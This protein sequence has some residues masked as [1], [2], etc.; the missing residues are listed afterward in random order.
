REV[1]QEKELA[2]SVALLDEFPVRELIKRGEMPAEKNR[3]RQLRELLR[4]FGVGSV[5]AL[6]E[7]W[8]RGTALR[9][10]AAFKSHEGALAAWLRIAERQAEAMTTAPFDSRL[11]RAL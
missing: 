2:S 8:L 7:V 3:A 5:A 1:D 9:K 10:S 6:K 11:C 4:F